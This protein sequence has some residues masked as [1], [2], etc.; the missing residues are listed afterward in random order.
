MLLR[1]RVVAGSFIPRLLS[2]R[3]NGGVFSL[4]F[5]ENALSDIG[6]KLDLAIQFA[7]AVAC[8]D[9]GRPSGSTDSDDEASGDEE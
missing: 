6:R 2:S 8:I 9:R 5:G 1:R 7:I 4:K 3:E